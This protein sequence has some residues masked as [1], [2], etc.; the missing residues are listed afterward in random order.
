MTGTYSL[1]CTS[2]SAPIKECIDGS[3]LFLLFF[4]QVIIILSLFPSH[5]DYRNFIF[6]LTFAIKEVVL[7]YILWDWRDAKFI[8]LNWK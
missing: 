7:F 1:Y 3:V 5:L 6:L 8:N 4:L 2:I